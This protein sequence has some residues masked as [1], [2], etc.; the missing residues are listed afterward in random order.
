MCRQDY[1]AHS[2]RSI[3]A[4]SAP[5]QLAASLEVPEGTALLVI[6]NIV[7]DQYDVPIE[8][9]IESISGE[10]HQFSFDVFSNS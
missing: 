1:A 9:S 10:A 5:P 2:R 6:E 7:Y 3:M 4:R 8:L